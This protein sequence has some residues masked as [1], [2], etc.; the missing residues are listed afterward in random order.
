MPDWIKRL[1][2]HDIREYYIEG[3]SAKG[4]LEGT[5]TELTQD[6]VEEVLDWFNNVI[7]DAIENN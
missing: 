3:A 5:D 4:F 1:Y 2:L 7:A 6:E